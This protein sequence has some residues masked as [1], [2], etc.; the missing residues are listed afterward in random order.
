MKIDDLKALS[1]LLDAGMQFN[2][3]IDLLKDDFSIDIFTQIQTNLKRGEN[4][5]EIIQTFCD[6]SIGIFLKTFSTYLPFSKALYLTLE[7]KD[8]YD[9]IKNTLYKHSS[10][11]V[12]LITLTLSTAFLFN[13]FFFDQLIEMISGFQLD[14]TMVYQAK[15]LITIILQFSLILLLIL[16][17]T[18][19]FSL[20]NQ[21]KI[22]F[23]LY[24][25]KF[26][27]NNV[28][29]VYASHLFLNFYISCLKQGLKT[30][31]SL[32]LLQGFKELKYISFLAY[33]INE[34]FMRG[35]TY[36]N[37]IGNPLI[38]VKMKRFIELS[39]YAENQCE[40]L[41]MYIEL[42]QMKFIQQTKRLG[43]VLQAI[44]YML[45]FVLVFLIYNILLMP[46]SV[47][48]RF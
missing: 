26:F 33:H 18:F 29:T 36:S 19:R 38:D 16:L 6:R 3:A 7:L 30:K 32:D 15:F 4:I 22:P 5:Y 27:P 11:P 28:L 1:L 31:E 37:A 2:Q 45:I 21:T 9:Q 34:H 40:I 43:N 14:L 47:I 8:K 13:T 44:A 48:E 12:L 10:Y 39:T 25:N 41:T 23:F 46:M 24:L 20:K 17:I 42:N 35:E